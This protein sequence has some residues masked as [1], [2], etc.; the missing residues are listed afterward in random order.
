MILKSDIRKTMLEKRKALSE[1]DCMKLDD[2][3]LIQFQKFDWSTVD[4]IG[5]FY[6]M[7]LYNEPNTLLLTRYLKAIIPNLII[8]YPKINIVDASMEFYQETESVL[9]NK[10]GI[11]E[12]APLNKVIPEQMDLIL[13]PLLAFDEVGYR[14]G[15]GKGY[16]DRYFEKYDYSNQKMGIS[17]F[18]ASPKIE[19]TDHFDVPL[20][21]CITPWNR[22]EF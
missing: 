17:Y 11:P 8:A 16:Y 9:E 1:L 20:S 18:E 19:D 22:Y 3:L 13:V 6:P 2:L 10:W 12:P 7:E 21:Y 5:S 15:F 14:V 4:C